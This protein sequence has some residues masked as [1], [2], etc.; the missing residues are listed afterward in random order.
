MLKHPT[1]SRK[2]A[3][4]FLILLQ[5]Y[6]RISITGNLIVSFPMA[7]HL[8]LIDGIAISLRFLKQISRSLEV[9]NAAP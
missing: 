9:H 6:L 3:A 7:P 1:A 8:V 4:T 2:F 5:K